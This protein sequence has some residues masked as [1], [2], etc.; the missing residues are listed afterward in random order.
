MQLAR[1]IAIKKFNR[2]WTKFLLSKRHIHSILSHVNRESQ[3]SLANAFMS[4][5]PCCSVI[6]LDECFRL[7]KIHFVG[8]TLTCARKLD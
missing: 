2:N 4:N 7:M 3:K 5:R 6:N 1:A 8:R